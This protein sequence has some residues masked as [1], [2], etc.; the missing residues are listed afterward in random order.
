[1]FPRVLYLPN[2]LKNKSYFL[3]GPRATGKTSLIEAQFPSGVLIL[4]LLESELYLRLFT[5]PGLLESI[6]FE[7]NPQAKIVV[8]DE[9]QRIPAILNEVHRLIEKK[10]II[11]LLTGSSARKLKRNQANLLA[12]RARQAELFP[13]T[14]AEIPNFNLEKYFQV[15]GLPMM[16]LSDAPLDDLHAYVDTYLKEE[17]QAEALVRQL[18]SFLRFLK[19]SAISNG[20]IL[21]YNNIASDAAVAASTVRDYYSI[22]EDTFLGFTVEPW[23][24]SAKRK[25]VSKSKFYYFDIG[26]KNTLAGT[27]E[28][29]KQSDLFG[30]TFEHF[31]ALELRAYLSY[32][33]KHIPLYFWQT[34]NGLEV[35]FLIEKHIAIEVKATEQVHDKHLKNLKALSEEKICQQCF[36]VSQDKIKRR[37]G[38]IHILPWQDFLERLWSDKII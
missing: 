3:F 6:I 28:I 13:L 18:P 5:N 22:L 29:Q 31:I 34:Q 14:T 4:D 15:G 30:K 11:F 8:I 17:I 26:V 23:T 33:R 10:K 21:N 27:T 19:F 37:V 35:D 32:R 38:D 36:L 20:E 2:L 9:V 7:F 1:M 12:G 16:Y 24:K 25:V